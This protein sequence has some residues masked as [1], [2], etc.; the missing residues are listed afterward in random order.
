M[1]TMSTEQGYHNRQLP[2]WLGSFLFH[3]AVLTLFFVWCSFLPPQKRSPGERIAA[4]SIVLSGKT[5]RRDT[6]EP[7]ADPAAETLPAIFNQQFAEPFCNP[8]A[9]VIAPGAAVSGTAG[10]SAADAVK[11]VQSG[12][13]GGGSLLHGGETTVKIF[14]TE[15]KGT[16]FMFVFDRSLSM[17]GAPIRAAKA[18]LIRSLEA[19]G[20][21][22]QFN[23]LFYSGPNDLLFWRAGRKLVY[24]VPG[25]KAK[26]VGFIEGIQANGGTRHL[27]PLK[28]AVLHRPDVIFF[29]TDGGQQDDLKLHELQEIEKHNSGSGT[30]I[31]VIQFGRGH[32]TDLPSV[33]LQQLAAR[34]GGQYRYVNV[35]QW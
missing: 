19:L 8:A 33:S 31:N 21:L 15:G 13:N 35:T 12:G 25:E 18:E 22:H 28:E 7:A 34:N 26:A 11:Q 14:G 9:P 24:A 30:Q 29:L 32:L 6:P 27:E 23:I 20:D 3:I 16:K 2:A 10:N 17:A 5:D 1:S 4:G